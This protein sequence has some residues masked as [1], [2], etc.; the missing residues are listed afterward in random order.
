[1]VTVFTVGNE[2]AYDLGLQVRGKDFQKIGRRNG[3]VNHYPGGFAFKSADD[4]NK[5]IK[6][7][8]RQDEWAVYE[9]EADWEK[10]TVP[11]K[12][13]WWHA[14]INDVRIIR[15]HETNTGK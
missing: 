10:D 12:N 14:L 15:K 7:F 13:G 6:E 2:Q 3:L 11:S 8:E 5:L 4:A 1:M 9:L